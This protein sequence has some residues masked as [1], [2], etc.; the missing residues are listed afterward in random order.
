MSDILQSLFKPLAEILLQIPMPWR[1]LTILLISIPTFS[2]IFLR[3]SPWLLAKFSIAFLFLLLLPDFL[4]AQK[5]RQN[6]QEPSLNLYLFGSLISQ[7]FRFFYDINQKLERLFEYLLK[8]RWLPQIRWLVMV[9]IVVPFIWYARPLF[10]DTAV[11][12]LFDSS[13]GWWFSFEE[14]VISGKQASSVATSP[15]EL[16]I[17]DYFVAIN[18]GNYSHAWSCLS[19]KF[20]GNT[21]LM[22]NGYNSYLEWWRGR[23]KQVKITQINVE[24][25]RSNSATVRVQWQ[26]LL[27]EEQ[28]FPP[29]KSLVLSLIWD[30]RARNWLIDESK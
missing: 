10:G 4:L 17:K 9:G 12:K 7:I 20:Q 1:A 22:P 15:P 27:R 28:E 25:I 13:I 19:P 3:A 6:K 30:A 18:N 24:S 16:F 14:W 2:W 26:I 23:V 11:A 21:T 5:V 29:P 8:K